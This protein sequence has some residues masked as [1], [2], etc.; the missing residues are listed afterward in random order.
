[1]AN[2]KTTTKKKGTSAKKSSS[3]KKGNTKS[4][5]ASKSKK[6]SGYVSSGTG[7]RV[8]FSEQHYNAIMLCYLLGGTLMLALAL[9]KGSNIWTGLRSV[10]FSGFGVSFYLLTV[11]TLIIGKGC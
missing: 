5:S 9:I 3:S 6:K 11:Q 8:P 4:K 7:K 10:L 2:T 1:M